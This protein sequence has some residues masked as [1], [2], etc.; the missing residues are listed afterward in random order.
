VVSLGNIKIKRLVDRVMSGCGAL[1]MGIGLGVGGSLVGSLKMN[2][3]R[4]VV[5]T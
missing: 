4:L 3:S 2:V 5:L 1:V